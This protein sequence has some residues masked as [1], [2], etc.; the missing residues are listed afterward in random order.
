MLAAACA[1]DP[2]ALQPIVVPAASDRLALLRS[3]LAWLALCAG[4]VPLWPGSEALG[5]PLVLGAV[6][7]SWR[8]LRRV[9]RA[10]LVLVCASALAALL[11]APHMLAGA[12]VTTARLTSLVI[13]V[14]L[15]SSTLGK[16]RDLGALSVSLLA[17]R[18][19]PRYLS[20]SAAT[21]FLAMP[22]NFGSVGVMGAMVGRVMQR[23]GDTGLT[24]NAARAVLRGFGLASLASPL[25]ISLAI[26]LS[27]LPHVTAPQLIMITLPFAACYLWLGAVFREPE[28]TTAAPAGSS[29]LPSDPKAARLAW[30][31]F[32]AYIGA[33]CSGAFLLY[34]FGDMPYSR[35]VAI[36]CVAAV[37]V[38]LVAARLRGDR[39]S[40]PSIANSGNEL[41]VMCGSAFLGAII[42]GAGLFLLGPGFTLPAAVWPFVVFAV[43]WFMFLGGMAGLNPIVTGTMAGALLG[44]IAPASALVGLGVGMLAGWGMTV[45][46]TP[47][48]ASSMLIERLTGYDA[49]AATWN[50]NMKLSLCA[51]TAAGLLAALLTQWPGQR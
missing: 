30:L 35:A 47:Y 24:R 14:M 44:P 39:S 11:W 28:T 16:S 12:A 7:A 38:G 40:P 46:G 27:F 51:L 36:S 4:L 42:S 20:L 8:E 33:I 1:V 22:L 2:E 5:A 23:S 25:S 6:I 19:L 31:R 32:S 13:A 10:V 26:T 17:G 43:P 34:G 41:A 9:A 21:G 37:M 48:S 3:I 50:W 49:Q 45:A 29:L 18:S 15:L